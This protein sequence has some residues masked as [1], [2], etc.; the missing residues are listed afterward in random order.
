MG[1]RCSN[2]E[3]GDIRKPGTNNTQCPD[4]TQ[5]S[6]EEREHLQLMKRINDD[7]GARKDWERAQLEAALAAR[8]AELAAQEEAQR[9]RE[10]LFAREGIRQI[11][12][13][14]NDTKRTFVNDLIEFAEQVDN[15]QIK[16]AERPDKPGER[17]MHTVRQHLSAATCDQPLGGLKWLDSNK[18]RNHCFKC[19]GT[20]CNAHI[21]VVDSASANKFEEDGPIKLC[22][23]CADEFKQSQQWRNK[24]ENFAGRIRALHHND[25]RAL[26]TEETV[27]EWIE[28][29]SILGLT[30]DLSRL[31]CLGFVRQAKDLKL[32]NDQETELAAL[33]LSLLS[34]QYRTWAP[35]WNPVDLS[36]LK[37]PT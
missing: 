2:L 37:P 4:I 26:L 35:E 11:R 15:A 25:P 10:I 20:M 19:G 17:C 14:V 23:Q 8:E 7:R 24:L 22:T 27:R 34:R 13:R 28:C 1:V 3:D 9:Q 31:R 36:H 16:R 21:V 32:L 5:F 12:E 29:A 30:D 18:K 33:E 6:P